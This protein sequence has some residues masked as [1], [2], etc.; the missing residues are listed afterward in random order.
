[1]EKDNYFIILFSVILVTSLIYFYSNIDS[2]ECFV[3]NSTKDSM[4]DITY[5]FEPQ[6]SLYGQ[7]RIYRFVISSTGNDIEYYGMK[8]V[9][10][11]GNVLF[12]NI[13]NQ[14]DGGSLMTSLRINQSENITVD[15]F[16][17]RK[18]F[19]EKRL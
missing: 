19:P 5:D 7:T 3:I 1:M 8:I 2:F 6:G 10:S 15:R 17:K 16:F 18:C 12:S 13:K 14:P 11:K 9:D 4:S